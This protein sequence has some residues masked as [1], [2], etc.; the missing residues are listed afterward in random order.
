MDKPVKSI[1]LKNNYWQTARG[2]RIILLVILC[3]A[4]VLLL[5]NLGNQYLWQDEA[6]TALISKTILTEGVPRGYD[7]KN[8]FSQEG[9]AEYGEN[10]IW[11]WHTWLPFYVLAGFYKLFGV[12]TFVSRLPFVLFGFG[13][14][15][16]AYLLAKELWGDG[17]VPLISAGLLTLCVPFLLLCRQ[18][19]Y[20]SMVMFFTMLSLYAYA[21]FL[22]RKKYAV[23]MIFA[24]STLLFHSQHI[25]VAT[26][27]ATVLLHSII[28]HRDRLKVLLAV[29]FVTLL[30]NGPWLIW[31]AKMNYPSLLL[32]PQLWFVPFLIIKK[33][34]TYLIRYV[35]PPWLLPVVLVAELIR[36][37][38]TGTFTPMTL[39]LWEK[40]ALPAFFVVFNIISIA[41][42]ANDSYDR[43][44]APSIGLLVILIAV[45]INAAADAHVLVAVAATIVLLATGYLK[46]YIYEIAHDYNGPSEGIS[47]YLNEHGRPDDIVAVTYGEMPLKFYTK[48]R[49]TGG[50]TGENLEPARNARWVIIRRFTVFSR[51]AY[52]K[53]YLLKNIDLGGYRSIKI[54]Y[55]DIPFENRENLG[56]HLFRTRTGVRNV[57]IYERM[58]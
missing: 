35:F 26:F 11:R 48:M 31:Q 22:Q 36:R 43:Y 55:P 1:K 42:T 24:A 56:E 19:R 37:F 33:L 14:I 23:L 3:G 54:D 9:G 21:A 46:E 27:F 47:R 57:V 51:D 58:D 20:Y 25:Y 30:V 7:G 49:V 50:L 16:M 8:F 10:Y 17:C 18:C 40:V 5:A 13:T 2:Q 52:V 15:V 34:S 28:F 45:I 39:R 4:L 41:L 44:V 32:E 38:R 53:D 12:S 29:M 6:Q